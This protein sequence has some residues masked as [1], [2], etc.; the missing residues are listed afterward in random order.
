MADTGIALRHAIELAAWATLL[1]GSGMLGLALLAEGR[2]GRH[3]QS[4]LVAL[5]DRLLPTTSRKVAAAILTITSAAI[6]VAGPTAARGDDHVR[7]WLTDPTTRDATPST[8]TPAGEVRR[9]LGAPESAVPRVAQPPPTTS[10]T[11]SSSTTTTTTLP[12]V[13]TLPPPTVV[14]APA[15]VPVV[16]GDR[17]ATDVAPRR[18]VVP[19][20]P[21]SRAP[22]RVSSPPPVSPPVESYTVAPGDC[23]W[24]IAAARLGPAPTNRAVDRGWRAIWSANRDAVG[25][26]PGLIHPGLVLVIPVLDPT[27]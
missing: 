13:P 4:R 17:S 22:D 27:P 20:A 8:T 9:W 25:D 5:S 1:T 12:A 3:R 26:D 10:S 24:R 15:G 7:R 6:A 2:R 21:G 14:A 16:P 18:R 11:S 23:L 19:R